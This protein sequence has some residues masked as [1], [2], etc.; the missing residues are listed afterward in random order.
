MKQPL[1]CMNLTNAQ[2]G[3][4]RVVQDTNLRRFNRLSGG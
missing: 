3:V 2:I 1:N 4:S